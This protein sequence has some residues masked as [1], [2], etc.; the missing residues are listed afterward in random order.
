MK[1]LK[2]ETILGILYWLGHQGSNHMLVTYY[3]PDCSGEKLGLCWIMDT[4]QWRHNGRDG[5]SNHQPHDC[6]LNRLFRRRSEK[7]SKLRVTDFCAGNSLVTGEF[8]AQR[9]SNAENVF[10]WWRHHELWK[11]L[12]NSDGQN[13]SKSVLY[14]TCQF[15]DKHIRNSSSS[16][17]WQKVKWIEY[18]EYIPSYFSEEV[19]IFVHPRNTQHMVCGST[20]I[21]IGTLG[22]MVD[23]AFA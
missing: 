21:A 13:V 14:E 10:I 18:I 16:T 7:T 9:A 19:V 1:K 22:R 15:S 11:P 6:L 12:F 4:L 20:H 5:V 23:F 3:R 2:S 17:I 8:P